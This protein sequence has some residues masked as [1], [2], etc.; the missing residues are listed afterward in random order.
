MSYLYE[1]HLHTSFSS[2][3]ANSKGSEYIR[4]YKE[5]G[6]SGIIVTDHFYH[7]NTAVPRGL[8]WKE[9]VKQFCKGY[10]EA[11]NE[12]ERQDF[13][14]FFGWEETFEGCDDYLVYGLDREWLL[15]H[16]EA[17][18]WT[19]SQQYGAVKAAG[20]CVVQGHPFRQHSY[21]PRIVLSTGCVDAVE[22]ANATNSEQSYDALAMRYAQ[23]LR[24]PFTA[25]SDT[26]D[27]RQVTTD[28]VFGVYVK[29]KIKTINDFVNTI[30]TNSIAGIKTSEGRCDYYG[31]ERVGLPV[32][33]RD[34]NDR[35][36][37]KN[38]KDYI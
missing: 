19:R 21:I 31:D 14:V 1:T 8:P 25:G 37:G 35:I 5:L 30:C 29:E 9:W 11:K 34:K 36:T 4:L 2:A 13:D 10:E 24:L 20:G 28:G 7:G 38:W 32:V 18:D 27:A 12:G 16:Q 33:I 6:Y 3:C 17:K 26:H 15:E 22:A 23:K